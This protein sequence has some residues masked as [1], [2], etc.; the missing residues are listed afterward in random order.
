MS[1]NY[2]FKILTAGDGSV[3]KTAM[4]KRYVEGKWFFDTM[5]TIGVEFTSWEYII[6][7]LRHL[8]LPSFALGIFQFAV[9]TRLTRASLQEVLRQDYIIMA[10]SKGL[11][12]R[13]VMLKHGLRNAILPVVTILGLRLGTAFGGA[14]L[15]ETVFSYPGVGRLMYDALVQ[16]D[17]PII[18]GILIMVSITVILANLVVDILY[19]FIDPRVKHQ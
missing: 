8:V 6:D 2:T 9:L 3:G 13:T 17:Y 18:L 19:L 1:T 12:E 10:W 4:L 7:R 14:I 16:R 11:R 15:T 5:M